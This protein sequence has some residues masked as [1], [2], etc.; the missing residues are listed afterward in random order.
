MTLR[1]FLVG[2]IPAWLI[3]LFASPYVAGDD[4]DTAFEQSDR[5]Y[6]EKGY[7]SSIDMLG[8]SIQSAQEAEACRDRYLEIVNRLRDR[9]Y[10]SVSLK[11]TSMGLNQGMEF[12]RDN[13]EAVVKAAG[14]L[15]RIVTMD[16]EDS[17][18]V[19]PTLEIYRTLRKSYDNIGA[20]LQAKLFRTAEDIERMRD[21]GGRFRLCLGA[22]SEPAEIAHSRKRE[23]KEAMYRYA[24]RMVELGYYLE[25]ATHDD[26]LI[27]RIQAAIGE[28]EGLSRKMEIQW[29]LGV[30]VEE[31]RRRYQQAGFKTR[32]YLPYCEHWE[33]ATHYLKRRL[34]NNPHLMGYALSNLLK[35]GR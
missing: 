34:L 9:D 14:A 11:P 8:E 20:V 18:T 29:L 3:K 19:E 21:V 4:L 33:D 32:L 28:K 25:L 17:T 27:D 31:L 15:G 5:L 30:P 26:R 35:T 12:C 22:Y 13:I 10:C 16:M 2:M 24:L 6:R 1:E 23:A 7:Y